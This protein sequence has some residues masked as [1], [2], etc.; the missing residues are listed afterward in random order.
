VRVPVATRSNAY[1]CYRSLA[2]IVGSKHGYLSVVNVVLCQV[3]VSAT[4]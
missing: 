1:V 3:E 4:S 2:E